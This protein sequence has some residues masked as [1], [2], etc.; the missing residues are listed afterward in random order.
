M[1]N[2]GPGCK[3]RG[4]AGNETT[5]YQTHWFRCLFP[6]NYGPELI[7]LAIRDSGEQAS[8]GL[9]TQHE[10]VTP[11]NVDKIYPNDAWMHVGAKGAIDVMK[12]A[13]RA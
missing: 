12:R 8:T 1:C 7:K 11:E 9:F 3:Y 4:A 2:C 10:L 13:T 5:I 6:E